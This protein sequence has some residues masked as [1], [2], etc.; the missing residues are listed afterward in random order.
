MSIGIRIQERFTL[1][2]FIASIAKK[3]NLIELDTAIC[4]K[5]AFINMIIIGKSINYSNKSILIVSGLEVALESLTIDHF[6]DF[7]SLNLGSYIGASFW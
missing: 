5:G 2:N 6:L 4:A 7:Y 1:K 3:H